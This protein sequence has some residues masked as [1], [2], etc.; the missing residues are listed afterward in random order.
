ME[1]YGAEVHFL[2]DDNFGV[3]T[4]GNTA[5]TSNVAGLEVVWKL[6]DDK[7]GVPEKERYDLVSR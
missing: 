4:L 3:I 5:L 2:P 7:L 1:A 6:I